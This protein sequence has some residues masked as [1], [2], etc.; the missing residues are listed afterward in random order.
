MSGEARGGEQAG[1][2]EGPQRAGQQRRREA[3]QRAAEQADADGQQHALEDRE[4]DRRHAFEDDR[5]RH[6]A[7]QAEHAGEAAA[8]RRCGA[9]RSRRRATP[10]PAARARRGGPRRRRTSWATT[11]AP[12]KAAAGGDPGT[13]QE[14]SPA[15]TTSCSA[16]TSAIALRQRPACEQAEDA[17]EDRDDQRLA[18]DQPPHLVAGRRRARAARRSRAARCII[19]SVNVPAT[20]NSAT[21]PA[22]PPIVPKIATSATRSAARVSVASASRGVVVVEHLR[23]PGAAD[24]RG[25]CRKTSAFTSCGCAGEAPR[26]GVGEV[27]VACRALV[28]SRGRSPRP[29]GS[30]PAPRAPTRRR[31]RDLVAPARA[32]ARDQR[33]AVEPVA[34]ALD[35]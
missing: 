11:S 19:A 16:R 30:S 1:G 15:G 2:A 4:G 18:R 23:C 5:H 35:R 29:P 28:R 24:G 25:P 10:R 22:I 20:T 26:G 14:R 12:P 8:G 3:E 32:F 6:A 9:A 34:E 33:R 31:G 21:S 17:G 13:S 27:Q 7:A